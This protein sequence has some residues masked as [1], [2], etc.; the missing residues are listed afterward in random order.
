[1]S[2]IENAAIEN[3]AIVHRIVEAFNQRD[4]DSIDGLFASRYV[5]HDPARADA[6]LGPAGV[7]QSWVALRAAI[8]DLQAT[9]HDTVAECATVAVRGE[10]GG[11]HLGELMGLAPTGR[12]V[13]LSLIDFNRVVG[14]QVVERWAQADGIGLLRQLQEDEPA[15]D[16]AHAAV[17]GPRPRPRPEDHDGNGH[18]RCRANKALALRFSQIVLNGHRLDRA[19]DFLAPGFVGHLAGAPEPVTGIEAWCQTF[20][21]LL[22]AVPDYGETVYEVVA[23]GDLVAVRV[24][25][26]GTQAGELFNI[27]ATGRVFAAGGMAFFRISD[28]WIVEQWTEADLVGVLGQLGALSART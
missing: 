11:T 23:E 8:P 12:P 18:A 1:V 15:P 16:P 4:D 17:D 14:G 2:T 5:D 25:F 7:K 21:E 28:G 3:T 19:R 26:G 24:T 20:G 27:P 10:I 22:A 13:R 9:I 6:P